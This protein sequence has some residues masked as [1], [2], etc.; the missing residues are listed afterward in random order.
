MKVIYYYWFNASISSAICQ[1]IKF[2]W[3]KHILEVKLGERNAENGKHKEWGIFPH[4]E[5]NFLVSG[6]KIVV[7]PAHN[8][9]PQ[10][11][12]ENLF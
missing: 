11:C 1:K 2:L 12:A 6:K 10:Q 5:C 4:M 9:S 7:G 3:T 8:V